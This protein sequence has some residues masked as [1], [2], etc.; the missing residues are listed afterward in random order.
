[1]AYMACYHL[2]AYYHLWPN[3]SRNDYNQM[4][5]TLVAKNYLSMEGELVQITSKGQAFLKQHPL[6]LEGLNGWIWSGQDIDFLNNLRFSQQIFSE[7]QYHE[8][9]YLP[10]FIDPTLQNKI[11]QQLKYLSKP[12]SKWLPEYIQEL[13]TFILTLTPVQQHI[14]TAQFVGHDVYGTTFAQLSQEMNLPIWW[15]H[16]Q[17]LCVVHQLMTALIQDKYPVMQMYYKLQWQVPV[18]INQTY[19][20]LKQ[21]YSVSQIAHFLH[22]KE[23]TISDYVIEL[24][25]N[26]QLDCTTFLNEEDYQFFSHYAKKEPNIGMWKF[27]MVQEESPRELTFL[28]YRLG[29]LLQVME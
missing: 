11:K 14:F 2:Q 17:L 10:L 29:Q 7:K 9:H 6:Y 19:M 25:L 27:Q 22:R 12:F 23:G 20:Y 13:R 3:L 18:N 28:E 8:T 16:L 1:M 4:I 15:L 5:E 26:H 21:G 24:F